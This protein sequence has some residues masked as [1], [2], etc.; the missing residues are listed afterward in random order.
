MDAAC[1]CT[2]RRPSTPSSW[3]A[4]HHQ[5]AQ[6]GGTDSE[7]IVTELQ[8][9]GGRITGVQTRDAQVQGF[10][11]V[12]VAAGAF[13]NQL[14]RNLPELADVPP[15]FSGAGVAVVI[16]YLGATNYLVG[17]PVQHPLFEALRFVLDCVQ[18][19]IHRGFAD[20][21]IS[22]V[23]TGNRPVSVDAAPIIGATRVEVLF[24]ATG[25][26]RAGVHLSP[27]IGEY[28]AAVVQGQPGRQ[29]FASFDP[30]RQPFSSDRKKVLADAVEQSLATGDEYK[31]T[32]PYGIE[33][34]HCGTP[35]PVTAKT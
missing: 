32:V 29:Q 18:G 35:G 4:D 26:Y 31:W 33:E 7:Q 9:T 1:W 24:L 22:A 21:R 19:Q 23:H 15:V 16:E 11:V 13:S 34:T 12:V 8:A 30:H 2:A 6:G 17:E 10:D 25:T 14:I 3:A 27:L 5:V 20:S 28:I